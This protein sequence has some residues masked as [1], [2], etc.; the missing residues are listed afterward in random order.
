[1]KILFETT[2]ENKDIFEKISEQIPESCII[3]E[4]EFF[5]GSGVI[6]LFIDLTSIIAPLVAGYFL[7]VRNSD[8]IVVKING[9]VEIEITAAI[10]KRSMKQVELAAK[11]IEK[12]DL[13]NDVKEIDD[14]V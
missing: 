7:G 5:E 10:N 11:I 1:M 13:I 9:R 14:S 2:F 3:V 8:K 12:L 4:P 6:Q